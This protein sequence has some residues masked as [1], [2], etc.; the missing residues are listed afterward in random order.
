MAR[1]IIL[2]HTSLRLIWLCL[3]WI[4]FYNVYSNTVFVGLEGNDSNPGT[5]EEPFST[6]SH[7]I[8]VIGPGDTILVLSGRYILTSTIQIS[9]SNNG[10][11]GNPCHLFAFPGD[12]V[13][14]DFYLHN[15]TSVYIIP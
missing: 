3:I 2:N 13:I 5:I 6:I 4:S 9:S 14:L 1:I 12:T 8:S 11:P 10:S 7:A 15:Y